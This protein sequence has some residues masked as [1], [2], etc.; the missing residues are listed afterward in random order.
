MSLNVNLV[1]KKIYNSCTHY[2][3]H[4]DCFDCNNKSRLFFSSKIHFTSKSLLVANYTITSCSNK[5][6]NLKILNRPHSVNEGQNTAI[7][8]HWTDPMIEDSLKVLTLKDEY[9]CK[10]TGII[11]HLV[12]LWR[13][14]WLLLISWRTILLLT[15]WGTILLLRI[16]WI[17]GI[18]RSK[19]L[20]WRLSHRWWNW[21]SQH[22]C[23]CSST[24]VQPFLHLPIIP[25]IISHNLFQI[26][27]KII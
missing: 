5:S 25:L 9:E 4:F 21:R 3:F 12:L 15:S 13:W 24:F 26:R 22:C 6:T 19:W 2:N 14:I 23:L 27:F 7:T 8:S 1:L 20:H 11:K 17:W 18:S 10:Q 16:H